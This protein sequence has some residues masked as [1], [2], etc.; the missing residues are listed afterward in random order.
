MLTKSL[1]KTLKGA[2]SFGVFGLSAFPA[3]AFFDLGV[4]FDFGGS[5]SE[6]FDGASARLLRVRRPTSSFS[7]AERG[8]SGDPE[9]MPLFP[10]AVLVSVFF[11]FKKRF[12][13]TGY[14][15]C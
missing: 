14:L 5:S 9:N 13:L 12:W 2:V 15:S 3:F 11:F 6:G 8:V 7:V 10:C 1:V 4:G